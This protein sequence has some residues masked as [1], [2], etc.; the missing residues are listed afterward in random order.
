MIREGINQDIEY[1]DWHLPGQKDKKSD[2]GNWL[3]MGCLNKHAHPNGEIFLKPFQK[4]CLRA[5]CE[6]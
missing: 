2:C 6:K 1:D 4:S 3:Y 5:D